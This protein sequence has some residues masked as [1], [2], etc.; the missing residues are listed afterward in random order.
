MV[1]EGGIYY[2]DRPAGGGGIHYIDRPS[3]ETRL[4]YFDFATRT[5]RTVAR[6]LGVGDLPLTASPDGHTILYARLDSS[7][8][9]LYWWRTLG[10]RTL[11]KRKAMDNRTS[12]SLAGTRARDR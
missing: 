10:W 7:V 8:D 11:G 4:Q 5:S 3:G 6:N 9:D 1:R 2:M 12:Q